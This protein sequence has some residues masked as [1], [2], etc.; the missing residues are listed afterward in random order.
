MCLSLRF[1]PS[2][3]PLPVPACCFQVLQYHK[4]FVFRSPE[5]IDELELQIKR[6]GQSEDG[7]G[8]GTGMDTDNIPPAK[9]ATVV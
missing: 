5:E 9:A 3:R 4:P 8:S 2:I 1:H 7:T 6:E